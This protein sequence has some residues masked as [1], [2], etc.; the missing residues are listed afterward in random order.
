[1]KL[2]TARAVAFDILG[3]VEPGARDLFQPTYQQL[4]SGLDERL[5]RLKQIQV[6]LDELGGLF[7][8]ALAELPDGLPD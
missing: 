1:M 3:R 8:T 4:V 2:S 5:S 7:D 6:R